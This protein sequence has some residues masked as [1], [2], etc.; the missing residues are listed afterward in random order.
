MR[1]GVTCGCLV[2]SVYMPPQYFDYLITCVNDR[3]LH[4]FPYS[5]VTGKVKDCFNKTINATFL[6]SLDAVIKPAF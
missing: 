1:L 6:A 2:V 4:L 5:K 3:E